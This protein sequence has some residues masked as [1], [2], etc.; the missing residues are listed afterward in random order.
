MIRSREQKQA[1]QLI[2]GYAREHPEL[3]HSAS[4]HQ[5]RG[6][7]LTGMANNCS[8]TARRSK[9]PQAARERSWTQ[10]DQYTAEARRHLDRANALTGDASLTSVIRRNLDYLD[11]LSE[12]AFRFRRPRRH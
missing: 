10:F 12:R 11:D 9:V 6:D 7:A 3:E 2:G 5:S 1:L 4:F 8:N